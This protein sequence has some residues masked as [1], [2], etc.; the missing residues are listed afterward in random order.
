MTT[1]TTE[2]KN[3]LKTTVLIPPY[4]DDMMRHSSKWQ[5]NMQAQSYVHTPIIRWERKEV[6]KGTQL[7]IVHEKED[8]QK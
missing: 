8:K 1:K 6:L 3:Y 7:V 5:N 4:I 2:F